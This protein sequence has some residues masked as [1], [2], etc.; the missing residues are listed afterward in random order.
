MKKNILLIGSKGWIGSSVKKFF[1]KYKEFTI[2]HNPDLRLSDQA[3]IHKLIKFLTEKKV[4]Y[5]INM[6]RIDPPTLGKND[7]P[8]IS[9]L[10]S[11]LKQTEVFLVH[12]G[13]AAEYGSYDIPIKESFELRPLS[14]YG[15]YKARESDV[16]FRTL[17]SKRRSFIILRPFNVCGP[18]PRPGTLFGDCARRVS[19]CHTLETSQITILNP[20]FYRDFIHLD[21]INEV[22]LQIIKG[23]ETNLEIL[24]ISSN[25]PVSIE[26]L[27]KSMMNFFQL[28]NCKITSRKDNN[29][30]RSALG[31]DTI[32]N[33]NF[34]VKNKKSIDEL[35][36][37]S[38]T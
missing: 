15:A 29:R 30:I 33:L 4:D 8:F 36:K 38:L 1:S 37:L 9:F 23:R 20:N 6:A 5:L 34:L 26:E 31:D 12:F 35:I 28:T 17:S 2:L 7:D 25:I 21:L 32:L 18:N 14:E 19:K 27:H 3:D 11:A 13:S 10:V 24:N 16:I 22:I